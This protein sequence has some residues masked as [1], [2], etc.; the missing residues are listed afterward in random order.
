MNYTKGPWKIAK[1]CSTLVESESGRNVASSGGYQS[2]VESTIDE[3]EANAHLIKAIAK[4]E[5]KS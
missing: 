1:H 2:N 3:N 4:A 5:G